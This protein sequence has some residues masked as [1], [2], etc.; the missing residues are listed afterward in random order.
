MPT[1]LSCSPVQHVLVKNQCIVTE[2][3]SSITDE[4]NSDIDNREVVCRE[5]HRYFVGRIRR[6][7]RGMVRYFGPLETPLRF[8]VWDGPAV[9]RGKGGIRSQSRP[10]QHNSTGRRCTSS[11]STQYS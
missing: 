6:R 10:S 5:Y 4:V 11:P 1:N 7:G 9:V 2:R 3:T 8:I